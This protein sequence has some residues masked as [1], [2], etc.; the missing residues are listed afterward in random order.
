M[1]PLADWPRFP[2]TTLSKQERPFMARLDR[3]SRNS[4]MRRL[5]RCRLPGPMKPRQRGFWVTPRLSI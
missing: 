3:R 4:L 1:P 5:P 2:W